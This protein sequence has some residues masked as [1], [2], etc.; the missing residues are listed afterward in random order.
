MPPDSLD[1]PELARLADVSPRT[2]RY[3]IQQG[4]LPAPEARGPG[5]HYTT[6][7]LDRLRL[8]KR[9]QRE[10]LPL[11]EIRRRLDALL[12]RDIARLA[13]ERP[14]KSPSSARDYV[15]RVLGEPPSRERD[16]HVLAEP[17][18]AGDDPDWQHPW[19]SALRANMP[20]QP[21]EAPPAKSPN[22]RSQWD[23]ITLAS[24]V[25]LHV[26]RPLSREQNRQVERLV[27]A[28]RRIF[29]ENDPT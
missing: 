14:A 6:E 18:P 8:I 25:E 22:S 15:R 28:A 5:A 7:H 12:P 13:A 26:R 3:Y 20:E 23:R 27:E 11:A 1:L 19:M 4:L 24:D 17:E 10:H 9:L 29:E 2:V 21:P 16:R